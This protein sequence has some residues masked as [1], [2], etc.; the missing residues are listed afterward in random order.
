MPWGTIEDVTTPTSV[1]AIRATLPPTTSIIEDHARCYRAVQSR[2]RRFDGVFYTAVRTTGIYCRPSC[3]AVTPRRRNVEF[4]ATAA[5]AQRAGYRACRRCLPDAT[6]GSAEWDVHADVAGRAMRLINDGYVERAG[7]EGLARR[8][9]YTSRHLTRVLTRQL[10]AGPLALARARRAQAA[11]ILI[12]TTTLPFGDVSFA[13]GFASIRQFNETVREV[14]GV[15]P[16]QLRK[17]S[18]AGTTTG[19]LALRLALR[20]PFDGQALLDFLGPRAVPGVEDVIDGAY[21]RTLRLP[22]G[23]GVVTL[24]PRD[25]RV[26]A[27]LSVEDLRDVPAVVERCRRLCDLD[28]DPAAVMEVLGSD[29]LMR[30][31]LR[32]RPGLRVPGHAD[33]TELAVRAIL[34]QQITVAAARTLAGRLVLQHGKPLDKPVGK[35]THVFPD[36]STLAAL[37]PGTLAMPRTRA[38]ALVALCESIADGRVALDRSADRREVEAMLLEVPGIG[39]WTAGYI[40]MRALGDPDVFL[41]TDIGVRDTLRARHIDPARA[42][43][44]ASAWRPWRSYALM[45]LW[46]TTKERP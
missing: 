40:A 28:A 42:G 22:H 11:R 32:H 45:H 33:G 10:G 8:L 36:A 46:A 15:T 44:L 38:R 9:G 35:L 19:R 37:D 39:P 1:P 12:E 16:T 6:P 18:R 14:Y 21:Q 24:E 30:P 31:L 20:T 34:G 29:P 17:G 2:D 43:E 5:A 4:F 26:D 7:V 41:P 25:D 13:A 23:P 3:P 27:T